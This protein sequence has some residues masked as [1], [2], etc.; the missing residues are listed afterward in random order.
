MGDLLDKHIVLGISGGIA[1]YKSADL[2]RR[3]IE[4]GA[5]VDVVM[6][7]SACKF[8]TPVTFQ[9]LSGRPV[10]TD[11]WDN[12]APNNMVHINLTRQADLVLI[13]PATANL[14]AKLAQGLADDLL[15][16]LCLASTKPLMIA[17][18]MNRE[19]WQAPSTQRNV[20]QLRTDGVQI[21]GPGT[22]EQA[23]GETGDGRMLE[24]HELVAA[25][26][27]HFQPKTMKGLSVLLTAGPTCEPIDPVR[28][29]TNR[30]SGK[31][32][33][34]LAQ[35]A[36]EAGAQVTLVS[37]PTGLPC[38]PGVT[39]ISVQTAQQMHQAVM[40]HASTSD[41]FIAVAAVADWRV[42]N[43]STEKLKKTDG[44][45]PKL[46]FAINPD[47]LKDVAGMANG[48]WCVGFAAETTLD[49]EQAQAKRQRKAVPL[50]IANLA[51]QVM[52][53]DHT[54]I[55]LVDDTGMTAMGTGH[56]L[57][58]A[59]KLMSEIYKRYRQHQA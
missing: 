32:G 59:R 47:I 10:Y 19:M 50:L 23:C 43:A 49:P 30:S 51:Q 44:Q 56:K 38:P 33:Y 25:V 21:L 17:P 7:D 41:I 39:R 57:D 6:T 8:V 16:T 40:Q 31:T 22:G 34:A 9:A 1:C 29:I 5:T 54:T 26:R 46:E 36:H 18:A 27:A 14:M 37:G 52:D 20:S 48:P 24:P 12:R 45:P 53:A 3:L 13:A 55:H 35:A 2:V 42:A 15:T 11:L 58:I 28:V 4:Q